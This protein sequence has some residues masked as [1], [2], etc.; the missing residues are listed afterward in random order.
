MAAEQ[1][2][3]LEQLMGDQFMG[4]G[5]SSKSSNLTLTSPNVCRS[6]LVGTCPHDLFT[7]TKQDLGACPKAHPENL[8]MEYD[9]LSAAE[10]SKYGFEYDYMRDM[11]KYIDECNRRIDQAQRRLEKTPDEIRQT[12]NL[13]KTISDLTKTINTGLLEVNCLA[14]MGSVSLACSEFYKVRTAKIA[15]EQA[16]RDLKSLSDTSGP[17]GHQ[18]LQVCD[19]C[20]AYLSRLDNDRRLADHFYGKM[21]L[22]YAQMRRT[23][24]QLQKELKGRPP[25][26]RQE[27]SSPAGPRGHDDGGYGDG[28]VGSGWGSRGGYGGRGGYRGGGG[29]R[30]RGRGR[31]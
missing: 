23:Y 13:L 22:G 27:E 16:E 5:T 19:V 29:Y 7:N 6:Y 18:K 30:G 21:H 1:R 12:N 3:L 4:A 17:S 25:P 2:K 9:G 8:K 15:K 10:K 31:W 24:E 26:V 28:G 11:Q 20:G 14:E